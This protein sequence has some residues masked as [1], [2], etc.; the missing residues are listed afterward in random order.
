VTGNISVKTVND[1]EKEL[2]PAE[3]AF[4]DEDQVATL[5]ADDIHLTTKYESIFSSNHKHGP[6]SPWA[7]SEIEFVGQE[8]VNIIRAAR[9]PPDPFMSLHP[10]K[11]NRFIQKLQ[12]EGIKVQAPA[13]RKPNEPDQA[14][15]KRIRKS[16][17][18]QGE[19][20]KGG[21]ETT[22]S[23]L[24]KDLDKTLINSED[25]SEPQPPSSDSSTCWRKSRGTNGFS[26][27]D[28]QQRDLKKDPRILWKRSLKPHQ[29]NMLDILYRISDVRSYV[30]SHVDI[31]SFS[32]NAAL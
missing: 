19:Q 27:S 30:A 1:L 32:T 15:V 7:A 26:S 4:A 22:T 16:A 8:A 5:T 23:H 10:E 3:E 9:V 13:K 21:V 2:S 17:V 6:R 12:A 31:Q 24:R 14:I 25:E 11:M 28:D 20:E 29:S 18:Q